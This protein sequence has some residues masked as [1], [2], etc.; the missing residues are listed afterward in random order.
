[1]NITEKPRTE[2]ATRPAS[3]WRNR[4]LALRN[5]F[6]EKGR[7]FRAGQECWGSLV[8]PCRDTAET[9]GREWEAEYP[10]L[11]KYLGAFPVEGT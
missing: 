6:D 2:K 1:M 9:H 5:H 10:K 11:A 8:F 4:Y 3:R 7:G